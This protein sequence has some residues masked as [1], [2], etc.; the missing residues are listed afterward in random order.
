MAFTV[1]KISEEKPEGSGRRLTAVLY[2]LPILALAVFIFL[3]LNPSTWDMRL[4][5][6]YI[7]LQ[8][9][10][11]AVCIFGMRFAFRV[12]RQIL[13]Y[14][15]SRLYIRLIISDLCAGIIYYGI[16]R[17]IPE[18]SARINFLRVV[19][20]VAFDLL[21]AVSARLIYQYIFEYGSRR[22]WSY[23]VFRRTVKLFTGLYLED[24]ENRALDGGTRLSGSGEKSEETARDLALNS[25]RHNLAIVGAGRIGAMLAKELLTNQHSAYVPVCFVDRDSAKSG[26]EIFGIPV[27]AENDAA[28]EKLKEL[29]VE[30][31]VFALPRMRA[32]RK[33]ELYE[34]YR[35]T[36]CRILIYDYPLSQTNE[37]GKR[38]IR[39]FNIEE[40]LFRDAKEFMSDEVMRFYADKVVLVTGGGGSIGS[41]L[42]RQIARMHPR[43]LI[44][45][46]VYENGAYDVQQELKMKYGSTLALDVEI[47]TVTDREKLDRIFES[48]KPDVVLHAAAHKHVPL[49]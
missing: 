35:P 20:I 11:G 17:I 9:V 18:H 36:G 39:E 49:M 27:I 40:L 2:D 31:I 4:R 42:C 1:N 16:Q 45:L 30:E 43:R 38:T 12:Y 7:L 6:K 13:R 22:L 14:G 19:C 26:R 48:Y 24:P 33:T 15:G 47:C 8:F 44:L 5:L 34:R 29:E 23:P 28:L 3:Y 41:E 46:D 25:D 21:G 37:F 10:I 32:E